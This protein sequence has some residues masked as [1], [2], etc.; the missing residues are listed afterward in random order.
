MTWRQQGLWKQQSQ[1]ESSN[2]GTSGSSLSAQ[3]S[4][5]ALQHRVSVKPSRA[6]D[7]HGDIS[8]TAY[9]PA[10]SFAPFYRSE[11]ENQS[12]YILV[13]DGTSIKVRI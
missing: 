9:E 13:S 1:A 11:A 3:D 12:D 8:P 4:G 2:S 6:F 5:Q 10:E 7:G